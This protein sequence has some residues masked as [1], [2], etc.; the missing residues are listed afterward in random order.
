MQSHNGGEKMTWNSVLMLIVTASAFGSVLFSKT[1]NEGDAA[2]IIGDA[3][4][5]I[6]VV[7]GIGLSILIE[8]TDKEKEEEKK[9]SETE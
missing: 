9:E 3:G 5:A 1:V 6:I 7:L 4:M 2:A 8:Q